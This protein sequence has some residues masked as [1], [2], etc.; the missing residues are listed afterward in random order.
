VLHHPFDRNVLRAQ[1]ETVDALVVP[2]TLLAQLAES[3]LVPGGDAARV[4]GIWRA[5]ERLVRASPWRATAV[6]MIDVQLFGEIGLI[7]ASRT[8]GGRPVA[9]PVGV[10]HAPRT[11][12]GSVIAVETAVTPHGTV[13][14]RGPMVPHASF[15]PGAERSGLPHLK[16]VAGGFVDTGQ[17][18][19][20]DGEI[21]VVTG[22]TTGIAAVGGYRFLLQDLQDL[23]DSADEGSVAV[24]PDGLA[25]QR[26]AGS[27]ADLEAMRASLSRLGAN[28]LLVDAFR[29]RSTAFAVR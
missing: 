14:L 3:D 10:L 22:P 7:A 13:G 21:M 23:V 26:L 16:V 12:R 11:P 5:P 15:P 19:R 20:R 2:G 18:C 29:R 4:I 24:L 6:P 27:A 28:P 1:I 25:G 17:P 8:P 9:T